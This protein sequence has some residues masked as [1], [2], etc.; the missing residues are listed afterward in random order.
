MKTIRAKQVEVFSGFNKQKFK[1]VTP[2]VHLWLFQRD[3][4]I[5]SGATKAVIKVFNMGGWVIFV[6]IEFTN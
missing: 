4:D 5:S 2:V 1:P 6:N 3:E